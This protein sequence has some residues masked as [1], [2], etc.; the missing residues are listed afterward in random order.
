[1]AG[2]SRIYTKLGDRGETGLVSGRRVMKN[3]P[4]IEA[5][6][7]VDELMAHTAL[8]RDLID[9]QTMKEDLRII[10][11]AEMTSASVLASDFAELPNRIPTIREDHIG[12]LENRID[13]M[14]SRLDPLRSFIVPGGHQAVSQAHVART[15]CRRVE[16]ALLNLEEGADPE[17][18]ILR[19]Y[20]RLSDYFFVL[21]RTIA[22]QLGVEQPP[23]KPLL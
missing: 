18:I 9:D 14:D 19:F 2:K 3:H 16:R 21:S 1:M 10:L 7:T 4:R 22:S 5:Y 17:G 15:V 12:F 6:G 8:L 20:N 23:W 11:D 13:R